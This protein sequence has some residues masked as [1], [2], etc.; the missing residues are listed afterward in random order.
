MKLEERMNNLKETQTKPLRQEAEEKV[1]VNFKHFC[2]VTNEPEKFVEK[3][4]QLC[5][6]HCDS[7][8]DCFFD[9]R[10]SD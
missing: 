5:Q 7:T 6:D 9:F 2:V 8:G 10:F 3:L 1:T 4:D